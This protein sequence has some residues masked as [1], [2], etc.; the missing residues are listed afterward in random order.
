MY[1]GKHDAAAAEA[2]KL[3]E[4]ARDDGDRR[5][6]MQTRAI[7]YVDQGRTTQAMREMEQVYSLMH[8]S[9]IPSP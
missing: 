9:V 8:A 1:Q 5:L 3:R 4:A 7:V 2:Q 6:A